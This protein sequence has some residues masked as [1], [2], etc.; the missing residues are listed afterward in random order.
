MRSVDGEPDGSRRSTVAAAFCREVEWSD[1]K[2]LSKVRELVLPEMERHGPI[3][4]WI[5]DDTGFPSRESTRSGS[6]RN[7][8]VSSREGNCRSR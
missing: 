8:A 2:V 4:V 1:E 7:I 3:E 6:R 5:I